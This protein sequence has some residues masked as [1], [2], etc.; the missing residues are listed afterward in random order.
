MI[1]KHLVFLMVLGSP[2]EMTPRPQSP[3]TNQRGCDPQVVTWTIRCVIR[4]DFF[5][6]FLLVDDYFCLF[7]CFLDVFFFSL[8][9][10]N[11]G[12]TKMKWKTPIVPLLGEDTLLSLCDLIQ[13]Y[14]SVVWY[15]VITLW[16]DTLL[17]L[18]G[19]LLFSCDPA[20]TATHPTQ[21][22]GPGSWVWGNFSNNTWQRPFLKR[23]A[24]QDCW[25]LARNM[26]LL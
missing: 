26:A 16:S 8:S 23:V 15:S 3:A 9:S 13:C 4:T 11:I 7:S 1:C 24:M 6:L 25:Q 19:Y 18:C 12:S 14:H 22:M 2:R 10:N 5:F 20:F 21:Q 17:L